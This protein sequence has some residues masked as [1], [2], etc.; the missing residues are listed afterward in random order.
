MCTSRYVGFELAQIKV[1]LLNGLKKHMHCDKLCTWDV[2]FVYH[3]GY[4]LLGTR[5]VDPGV[6]GLD[7]LKIQRG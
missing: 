5:G 1:D 4:L 7:P 6:G 3:I 2:T